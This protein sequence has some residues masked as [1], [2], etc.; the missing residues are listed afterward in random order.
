MASKETDELKKARLMIIRENIKLS[1]DKVNSI[2]PFLAEMSDDY[3]LNSTM[4]EMVRDHMALM[5]DNMAMNVF[6]AM[7]IPRSLV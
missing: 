2:L 1:D 4:V 6:E 5:T 3:I 7:A